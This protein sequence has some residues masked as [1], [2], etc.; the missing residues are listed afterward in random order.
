MQQ[1]YPSQDAAF[2][3]FGES[4]SPAKVEFYRHL[5]IDLVMGERSGARFQDAY[6]GRW[7]LNCHSNGGV[8][9]LGHRNVTVADAVRSGLESLD[10]GNHHLV[11]G[12]R[13]VL[14]E[15]LLATLN[16]QLAKVVFTAS[17]SE[18]ID[19][20]VNAARGVTGRTGGVSVEGAFKV[21]RRP[22]PV[23]LPGKID[24]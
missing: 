20:A 5:V 6:T 4:V 8:F 17:G 16:D 23:L 1:P 15:R 10:V 19:T 9:N 22:Y 24:R 3:A 13:A 14:G 21:R 11:S 2:N 7:Y 18:A 12:W